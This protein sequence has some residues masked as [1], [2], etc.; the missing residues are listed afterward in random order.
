MDYK[1][2]FHAFDSESIL[3]YSDEEIYEASLDRPSLTLV[4]DDVMIKSEE[5]Y[6]PYS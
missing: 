2:S 5:N 4:L 3:I 6:I 1:A